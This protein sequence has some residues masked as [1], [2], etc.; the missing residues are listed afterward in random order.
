M[1]HPNSNETESK[2]IVCG[3]DMRGIVGL[4]ANEGEIENQ[5]NYHCNRADYHKYTNNAIIV[6]KLFFFPL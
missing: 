6:V 2:E 5:P 4:N 3:K 1:L